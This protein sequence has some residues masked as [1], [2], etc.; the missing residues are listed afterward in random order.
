MLMFKDLKTKL[1]NSYRLLD[2]YNQD[3]SNPVLDKLAEI[4]FH[5][6]IM[7]SP[8]MTLPTLFERKNF[9]YGYNYFS[10]VRLREIEQKQST[11]EPLLY[12]L[13]GSVKDEES[14]VVSHYDLFGLL[15]AVNSCLPQMVKNTFNSL[16]T[17]NIL[18]LGF[19]F[20]KWYYQLILSLLSN[21]FDKYD[22]FASQ[23][24][25][26][27]PEVEKF[28]QAQF[29]I[30]FVQEN[31]TEFVQTL[32]KS[33]TSQQLRAPAKV[34]KITKNYLKGNIMKLLNTVFNA[35][36]LDTICLCNFEEVHNNFTPEQSKSSRLNLL[37]DYVGKNNKYEELLVVCKDE[38]PV[39]FEKFQPYFE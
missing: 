13:F 39:M 4:P 25:E 37:M 20:D 32:H 22:N 36:D 24:F 8:D 9:S 31:L 7:A 14:M 30:T 27:K 17:K 19:D 1:R 34:L 2:W 10:S 15:K 6:Y 35:S 18:F 5:T 11:A 28:C 29:N 38:N 3:F 23:S 33:F 26:L 12:H 21:D 16:T